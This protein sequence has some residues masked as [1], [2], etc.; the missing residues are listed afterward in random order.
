MK[1][2]SPSMSEL[3]A[4]MAAVRL[5]S[6]TKAAHELCLTQG[7]IS[8]AIARLEDHFGQPLLQRHAHGI[9]LTDSGRRL[10]DAVAGPLAAIET[11]SGE[12]RL[13]TGRHHLSVSVAPTLAS[14]W[15]VP[16]LPEFHRRHPEIQLSFA[17]YRRDEDFS[18]ASPHATLRSGI[19][20]QW[21]HWQCDYIVGKEIVVICHPDRLKDRRAQGRWNHPSEL[22]DE[23]LLYHTNAPDNWKHWFTAAGVNDTPKPGTALDQVSI[24]LRA[25]MVDMGIAVLQRCLVREEIESGRVAAPFDL[26]VSLERG[27]VLCCPLQRKDHPAL[28]VFRDWLQKEGVLG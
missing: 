21:P 14:V 13:A 22:L 26:P 19:P 17:A 24:I 2:H 11:V 18:Q 10:A 15:L 20:E 8:R 7:A 3:H 27:Y 6:F 23:P 28:V 1:I 4:F 16:R 5:G 25:V 9:T 12:L